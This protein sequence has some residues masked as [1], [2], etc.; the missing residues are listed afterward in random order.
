MLFKG[1]QQLAQIYQ[2]VSIQMKNKYSGAS[3]RCSTY[4]L[5]KIYTPL[6]MLFPT[7]LPRV[8]ERD[9]L[10][11]LRVIP[12]NACSFM[13]VTPLAGTGKIVELR[14][15][16]PA[17]RLDMLGGE[18]RGRDPFGSP[19]ILTASSG[20]LEYCLAQQFRNMRFSH[21]KEI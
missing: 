3:C 15:T 2:T 7:L 18:G 14:C 12:C 17:F 1:Y 20:S 21:R 13:V 5:R 19:T 10:L 6:E 8:K 4:E 11:C 9:L 16:S